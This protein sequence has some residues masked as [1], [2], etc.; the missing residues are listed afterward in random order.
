MKK[1]YIF[2]ISLLALVQIAQAQAP[3]SAEADMGLS[4][5]TG[6]TTA[7]ISESLYLGPG[8]YQIDGTWAIYSKNV[9]ISPDAIISGTG[10]MQFF[11]PSVA[12][13]AASPTLIDGNNNAGFV[14]VN[15]E[16][17]NGAGML[18][19]D[20]PA[21]TGSGWTDATGNASLTTGKNLLFGVSGGNILLGANDLVT[22]TTA[23]LSGY[24]PDRFVITDG[25]GH[26]VHTNYTG[27]FTY[28]IGI[29]AGDYTP[30]SVNSSTA[31]TFH[32]LVQNY[33]NSASA[34]AGT[35]GID[36]TW[37]I[38]A[39][40]AGGSAAIDLQH[41]LSTDQTDFNNTSAF[42]T[43]YGPA[44]PNNTGSLPSKS[45]WQSNTP[46]PG[47][48]TGA[49]TTA[50]AITGASEATLT[51]TGF[52]T[53]AADPIAFYSKSSDVIGPLPLHLLSFTAT[54]QQCNAALNWTTAQEEGFDHFDIEYS[55]DGGTYSKI[56]QVA[57]QGNA[58]GNSYTFNYAQPDNT[59]YYRL[60]MIDIDG[61]SVYSTITIVHTTGC[62]VG[63]IIISPNPTQGPVSFNGLK[64]G[65]WIRV[66]NAAGQ[67][68]ISKR[69]INSVETIDLSQ[70][71]TGSYPVLI[72]TG[73]QKR[74][75]TTILKLK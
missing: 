62:S 69:A 21:P 5:I 70:Q 9:W 43:R 26:L 47:S 66:F 74:L 30:A 40:N 48:S 72:Q 3:G 13:G 57:G 2:T 64:P 8:T 19:T 56:G 71:P 35:S 32:V 18:L 59:G 58:T 14:N 39:D 38:Y 60:K 6:G 27:S 31:N 45:S 52:A 50:S 61:S 28:P 36:R 65:D 41:N 54:A 23:T 20:Q 37:N 55:T 73:T 10:V 42:I 75:A 25:S 4:I 63:Q 7:T 24:Q 51:F 12:G 11:N 29:T 53:N 44:A 33:A 68:L 67:L 15:L 17:Q 22:A 34:E 1:I 16:L 49:L 46:A